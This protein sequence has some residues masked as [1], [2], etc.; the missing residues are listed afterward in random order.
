[1][2]AAIGLV[3]LGSTENVDIATGIVALGAT[4]PIISQNDPFISVQFVW[5][6]LLVLALMSGLVTVFCRHQRSTLA[7]LKGSF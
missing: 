5:L 4:Q 2:H 1:M 3:S 6:S 7:N